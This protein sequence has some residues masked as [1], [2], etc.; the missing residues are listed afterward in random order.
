MFSSSKSV[1]KEHDRYVFFVECL[2]G[3]GLRYARPYGREVEFQPEKLRGKVQQRVLRCM[4]RY[5]L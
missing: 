3:G 4:K 1:Y 2:R 5:N